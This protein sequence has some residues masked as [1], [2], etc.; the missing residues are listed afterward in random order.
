MFPVSPT[1]EELA[2]FDEASNHPYECRCQICL[3]WLASVPPEEE[4]AHPDNDPYC[5]CG[6][7]PSLD[8]EDTNQCDCCGKPLT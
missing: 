2:R 1:P 5:A 8:E 6:S 3:E 7:E 4:D